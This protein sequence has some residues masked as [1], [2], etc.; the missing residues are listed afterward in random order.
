M[1]WHLYETIKIKYDYKVSEQ[2]VKIFVIPIQVILAFRKQ[3]A[4]ELWV[5]KFLNILLQE[6]QVTSAKFNSD[7]YLSKLSP[8]HHFYNS[9]ANGN[10][11]KQYTQVH[12][13]TCISEK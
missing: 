8:A 9:W 4:E 10:Y 6:L 2:R 5:K 12:I 11:L 3:W 13:V 7:K 1:I